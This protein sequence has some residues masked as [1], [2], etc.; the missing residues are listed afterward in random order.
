[1]WI[2]LWIVIGY[3]LVGSGLLFKL[4]SV[5]SRVNPKIFT[6]AA[7]TIKYE[8]FIYEIQFN[9]RLSNCC[10]FVDFKNLK[11]L[12]VKMKFS[13][14]ILTVL[15]ISFAMIAIAEAIDW[16]KVDIGCTVS[17]GHYNL[18]VLR[19]RNDCRAPSGCDCS[20]FA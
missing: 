3:Y 1:M 18:C 6:T 11:K 5:T 16:G 4:C 12:C 17:C 13:G 8:R 9:H 14:L 20:R 7:F 15:L 2:E 10:F 19:N